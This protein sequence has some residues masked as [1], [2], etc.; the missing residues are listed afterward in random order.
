[1]QYAL[2]AHAEFLA[3][4]YKSGLRLAEQAIAVDNEQPY[5]AIETP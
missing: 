4:D 5:R 2:S 3:H 1:M